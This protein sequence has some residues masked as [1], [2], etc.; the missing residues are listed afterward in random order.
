M[1]GLVDFDSR[2]VFLTEGGVGVGS[3]LV[4]GVGFEDNEG[5]VY[6]VGFILD[7]C[8]TTEALEDVASDDFLAGLVMRWWWWP[9]VLWPWCEPEATDGALELD[10]DAEGNTGLSPSAVLGRFRPEEEGRGR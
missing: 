9:P 2:F 10:D 4:V 1:V 5:A 3:T 6:R 8:W 7:T